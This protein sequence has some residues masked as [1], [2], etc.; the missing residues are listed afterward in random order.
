VLQTKVPA[1]GGRRQIADQG[2]Q[3][4]DITLQQVLTDYGFRGRYA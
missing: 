1:S 3:A 4:A 2:R